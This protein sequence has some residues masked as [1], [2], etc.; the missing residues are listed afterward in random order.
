MLEHTRVKPPMKIAATRDNVLRDTA[1]GTL[2]VVVRGTDDDLRTVELSIVLMPSFKRNLLSSSAAA[3]KC[4]KIIIQKN[5][6]SLD[7]GSFSLQLTRL[8]SMNYLDLII[9]KESRR[10]EC[11]LCAISG[12]TFGEKSVLTAFVTF[13]SSNLRQAFS[14]SDALGPQAIFIFSIFGFCL[15]WLLHTQRGNRCRHHQDLHNPSRPPLG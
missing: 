10:T 3:K 2:L 11:I 8:D 13:N 12:E 4:V 7:L 14:P 6:S 1:H 15:M 5:G 9:P